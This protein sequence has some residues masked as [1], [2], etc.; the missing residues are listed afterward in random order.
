MKKIRRTRR[1]NRVRLCIPNTKNEGDTR[2]LKHIEPLYA[3]RIMNRKTLAPFLILALTLFSGCAH[4]K[5]PVDR[6]GSLDVREP[7]SL[8]PA[9]AVAISDATLDEIGCAALYDIPVTTEIVPDVAYYEVDGQRLNGELIAE[10]QSRPFWRPVSAHIK[11]AAYA[12]IETI[13]HEAGGHFSLTRMGWMPPDDDTGHPGLVVGCDGNDYVASILFGDD[14]WCPFGR[15][16]I[17][18]PDFSE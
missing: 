8:T 7:N 6:I 10:W 17:V 9:E 11:I 4:I 13:K 2:E 1:Q 18:I 14:D 5:S 3:T 15:C 12:P 16:S